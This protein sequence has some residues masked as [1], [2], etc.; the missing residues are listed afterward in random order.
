M[1]E[2]S[3][4]FQEFLYDTRQIPALPYGER[5]KGNNVAQTQETSRL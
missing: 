4:S 2:N 3:V 1:K 5:M